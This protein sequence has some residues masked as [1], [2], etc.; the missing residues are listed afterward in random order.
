MTAAT[1]FS[2][3]F[4]FSKERAVFDKGLLGIL[5]FYCWRAGL[6]ILLGFFGTGTGGLACTLGGRGFGCILG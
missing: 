4:G 5:R 2:L 3:S 6:G 1:Y